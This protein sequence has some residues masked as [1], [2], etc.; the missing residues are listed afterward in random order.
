M[1]YVFEKRQQQKNMKNILVVGYYGKNNLGDE[2]Y[3]GVMGQFFPEAEL[4]FVTS[5]SLPEMTSE[6]YDAVIVGGGDIINNYFNDDIR[7]FLI[8]FRGPRIAFSIGIPFPS[9]INDRYLGHFDHVF[10]RNYEDVRSIQMLLGSHK[11]HFIPDIALAYRPTIERMNRIKNKGEKK[12]GVFLVG[13]IIEFPQIAEDIAHIISK[14]SLTYEVVLYCFNPSEDDKISY[15]VRDSAV[16]R[17]NQSYTKEDRLKNILEKAKKGERIRVDTNG[18]EAQQ[19]IDIIADLD[20]AICMRYHSHIFCTV[21]ETPFMS[22]SS[23]RKTRSFMKQA[24]L[25][26]YQYEI[27]LDGYC[28]P[29][30]SNY[31]DM[32][33]VCQDSIHDKTLIIK[34]LKSFL[35]S[36][37]LLLDSQQA[38]FLINMNKKDIRQN[39]AEFIEE[40]GDYQNAARLLSNYVI[41]YPDSPYI[42]GMYEKF[43]NAGSLIVETIQDST[44]YLL[45]HG[46]TIKDNFLNV[47]SS[48]DKLPL[49][50]DIREYQSYKGAHRG[51]WYI[52]CEELSKFNSLNNKN[53]NN[54]IICDMY[55]DRTF[56][57]A[58]SYMKYQGIIPYTSPWCG[59]VHHTFDTFY[60]KYNSEELFNIKE[61][62]Q[63]LRTCLALFVLSE[64][65]ANIFRE[66]LSKI[67]SYIKV[68]TFSHPVVEPTKL[69]SL[70]SYNPKLVNIGAWLRNPFTIYRLNRVNIQR[71]I[72]LGKDMQDH[73]PPENF[74]ISHSGNLPASHDLNI[75]SPISF[76]PENDQHPLLPCRPSVSIPRWVVMLCRWL[77]SLD[78]HPLSYS[79]GILYIREEEK[80]PELNALINT[81]ISNVEIISYK[82]NDDYDHILSNNIVFL[83]LID[84]AA[85]NTIIECIVRKTP[86]IVNRIPGTV[87]LL[88]HD[89][90]LFYTDIDQIPN[91]LQYPNIKASHS[92]LSKIN[93][94]NFKIETFLSNIKLATKKLLPD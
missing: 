60:S 51:G 9:L 40:T 21:A 16:K 88:G 31:D 48:K 64:P 18:Y 52:A 82:S 75:I 14:V 23:T 20:F 2:A 63:S 74:K 77:F 39:V 33:K 59:F 11:A 71:C 44:Q 90:P 26:R 35:Y 73:V 29:T 80:V 6:G 28:K 13:N 86:V 25:C 17:L 43:K 32:R 67:A 24:S 68:I 66:K 3:R 5:R 34:T 87:A 4:T 7:P 54:G 92:Y 38:S 37:R 65:L 55:V 10:T 53:T 8:K 79:N 1:S 47:G 72:L 83:D 70:S 27:P 89:Y 49:Y 45:R 15:Y 76:T 46:A 62:L 78:I 12:C 56:H 36:S 69:F 57:W 22:I 30:R 81:M 84:A 61:F 94:S 58:N 93:K 19:M 85:V 42:W 41:G 91:L 50:V